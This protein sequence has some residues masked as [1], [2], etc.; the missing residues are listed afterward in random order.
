MSSCLSRQRSRLTRAHYPQ[1]R[2]ARPGENRPPR[3]ADHRLVPARY[4][5]LGPS[6]TRRVPRASMK[7]LLSILHH[8]VLGY[9]VL[10]LRCAAMMLLHGISKM[11]NGIAGIQGMSATA[12]GL[13]A[14]SSPT[15]CSSGRWWRRCSVIAGLWVGPAGA[16]DGDQHAVRHRRWSHIARSSS[17]LGTGRRLGASRPQGLFLFGSVALA[18]L[19]PARRG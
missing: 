16:G 5:T 18:L 7:S 13:P 11:M 19:A 10:R 15:A 2:A 1:F 3:R 17:Q 4:G 12:R 6:S 9:H 8:P 14:R